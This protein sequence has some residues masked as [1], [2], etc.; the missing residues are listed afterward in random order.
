MHGEVR[1]LPIRILVNRLA[2]S[3]VAVA[4]LCV[5]GGADPRIGAATCRDNCRRWVGNGVIGHD[6]VGMVAPEAGDKHHEPS[7]SS[8][9]CP[10]HHALHLP[11]PERILGIFP[12]VLTRDE[13]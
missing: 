5:I 2:C 11:D 7:R 3:R 8:A 10:L 9:G 12:Q 6:R 4:L 13:P 1:A